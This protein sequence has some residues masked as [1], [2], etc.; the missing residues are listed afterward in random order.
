M[1]THGDILYFHCFLFRYRR[2]DKYDSAMYRNQ[3]NSPLDADVLLGDQ[4]N[5][6]Y[7]G[8]MWSDVSYQGSAL[9]D[10]SITL[11]MVTNDWEELALTYMTDNFTNWALGKYKWPHSNGNTD[12]PYIGCNTDRMAHVPKGKEP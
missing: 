1:A 3:F 8:I 7:G 12:T 6:G 5:N 2:L 11:A 4:I 10:A 9:T